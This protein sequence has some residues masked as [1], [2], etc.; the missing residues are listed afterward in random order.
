VAGRNRPPA[1]L[2]VIST[3]LFSFTNNRTWICICIRDAYGVFVLTK[4]VSFPSFYQVV[5]IDDLGLFEALQR[6]S[7]VSFEN[8]D[9]EID[10]KI[11]HDV[12]HS[13]R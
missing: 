1:M 10:S 6:L 13:R 9:F 4:T 7:D 11:T 5:V 3:L 12:F 2:N 8:I